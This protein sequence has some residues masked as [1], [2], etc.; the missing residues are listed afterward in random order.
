M[1]TSRYARLCYDVGILYLCYYDYLG[2]KGKADELSMPAVTG[3]G[4]VVNA[5][6]ASVWF[7]RALE[8]CCPDEGD[9]AGLRWTSR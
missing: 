4:A 2:I 3:Q 6:Q 5:T 8:A 1:G 7:E 9:Y